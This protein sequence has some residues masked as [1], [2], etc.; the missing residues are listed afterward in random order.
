MPQ[1]ALRGQIVPLQGALDAETLFAAVSDGAYPFWLDSAMDPAKLGR[2]S[3]M[4]SAPYQVLRAK[5]ERVVLERGGYREERRGDPWAAAEECWR[6]EPRVECDGRLP[7]LGGAV[8]YFGYELARHLERLPCRSQDD[9]GTDDLVLAFYDSGLGVDHATGQAYAFAT[10]AREA[11]AH[12]AGKRAQ[13]DLELLLQRVAE[14]ASRPPEPRPDAPPGGGLIR[15][16]VSRRAYLDKVERIK[17][18]IAAG[19]ALE[20]CLTH[21]L[22][23]PLEAEPISLYRRLRA[24]SPAPFAAY[25]D[26]GDFQLLGASPERFLQIVEGKAQCRPIKGTRPRGRTPDEDASLRHALA[27]S[28]KDRCENVM[29]VDLVRNDLGRVCR[30]GSVEVTEFLIIEPYANVFQLVSTIEG[31]LKP[32]ADPFDAIRA[33]F[34]GGSMTG[35]PK[36]RAMEIIDELEPV[37]RGPYAG[38][39]GYLSATGDVDLNIVI[40][41]ILARGGRAYFHVGGAVVAD[42]DPEAEWRETLDK[43]AGPLAALGAEVDDS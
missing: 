1:G 39:L 28:E 31:E 29:I 19:D 8:G 41:T 5:G 30:I 24:A 20:V 11:T 17:E 36:I 40:R 33:C 14:A 18:Y 7:F 12:L 35:A 13:A 23:G 38:A 15:P 25:L 21:R 42:S 27:A 4:G 3:F 34:P 16:I 9:L 26:L 10:G 43:A 32:D 37:A 2:Y 6:G 22:D